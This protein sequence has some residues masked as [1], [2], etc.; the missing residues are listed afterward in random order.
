VAA[1]LHADL[2]AGEPAS[3]EAAV[4]NASHWSAERMWKQQRIVCMGDSIT[5]RHARFSFA[6]L[7][8]ARLARS[9]V[10]ARESS[11]I[12]ASASAFAILL[13]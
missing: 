12:Q 6:V 7:F 1:A 4:E 3:A 13:V 2:I 11:I 10:W 8:S 9:A 5:P